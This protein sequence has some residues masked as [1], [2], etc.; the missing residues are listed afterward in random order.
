MPL[1]SLYDSY[2]FS[3]IR[4]ACTDKPSFSSP[5]R[6]PAAHLSV[7]LPGASPAGLTAEE[8]LGIGRAEVTGGQGSTWKSSTTVGLLQK[9][10]LARKQRVVRHAKPTPR[11]ATT[12]P[13][14]CRFK[15]FN[16]RAHGRHHLLN[17]ALQPYSRPMRCDL[18]AD[19]M[20][21][22]S[23]TEAARNFANP[24]DAVDTERGANRM[25]DL[26]ADD[27]D[28]AVAAITVAS[29]S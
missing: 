14:G 4:R 5:P 16:L 24:L 25:D 27:D 19:H 8:R 11:S 18:I 7:E 22:V 10:A 9:R 23:A 15:G 21:D 3:Y 20:A 26:I 17:L 13:N 6:H 12:S 2:S 29:C 1:T 28:T